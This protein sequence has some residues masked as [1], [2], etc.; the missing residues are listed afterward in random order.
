MPAMPQMKMPEMRNEVKLKPAGDG[1]YTASGRVMMAGQW[2]VTVSV[3]QNGKEIG[4]KK[5]TV[6]AK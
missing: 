5:L 6:T 4:Q 3:K 1:K 2:N